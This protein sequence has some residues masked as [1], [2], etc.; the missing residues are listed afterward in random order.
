MVEKGNSS[1]V[2]KE[3]KKLSNIRGALSIL[4]LHNMVDAQDE[5]DVKEK[6]KIEELTME[7]AVII[8]MI[9]GLKGLKCKF[10]STFKL[11]ET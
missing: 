11:I 9:L 3:L 10:W 1:S 4:G 2:I 8:L 7:W 6:L 5:M